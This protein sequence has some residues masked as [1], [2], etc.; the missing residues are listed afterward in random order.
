MVADCDSVLSFVVL[1]CSSSAVEMISI[2]RRPGKSF[3]GFGAKTDD[4]L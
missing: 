2:P 4:A 1:A 3:Y